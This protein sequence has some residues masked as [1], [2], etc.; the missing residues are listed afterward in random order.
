MKVYYKAS[1][2]DICIYVFVCTISLTP[3]RADTDS[4]KN[5]KCSR[6]DSKPSQTDS[7]TSPNPISN[8]FAPLQDRSQAFSQVLGLILVFRAQQAPLT[9]LLVHVCAH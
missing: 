5:P 6:A 9:A 8:S 2:V 4:P 3:D 1:T 7:N